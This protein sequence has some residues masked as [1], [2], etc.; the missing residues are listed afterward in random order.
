MKKETSKIKK[1]TTLDTLARLMAEGFSGVHSE[2]SGIHTEISELRTEMNERFE[3]VDKRFEQVDRRF[4]FLEDKVDAGF[5]NVHQELKDQGERLEKIEFAKNIT[6]QSK[7][8][9]VYRSELE[10]LSKRVTALE[11]K[12]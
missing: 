1:E 11:K 6:D 10:G 5:F 3:Q 7:D 8:R 2:I 4:G 12:R 9:I